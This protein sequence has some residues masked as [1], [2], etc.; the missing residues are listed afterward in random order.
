MFDFRI[1]PKPHDKKK[2]QKKNYYAIAMKHVKRFLKIHKFW[3]T[4]LFFQI[5]GYY[6][7]IHFLK[8]FYIISGV[9]F[10]LNARGPKTKEKQTK[11]L[12]ASK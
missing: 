6:R 1:L 2:A 7:Q 4:S 3:K 5:F 11:K 10:F 12:I 8:W 9:R